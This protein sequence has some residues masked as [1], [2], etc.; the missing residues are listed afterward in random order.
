MGINR[1]QFLTGAAVAASA[2]T[3]GLAGCSGNSSDGSATINFGWWGNPVRNQETDR[4]IK[5]YVKANPKVTIKQQPGEWDSYWD[6]L[7]TEVAGK[8]APDV[9]QMDMAYISQYAKNGTLLDLSKYGVDVSKFAPGTADAGRIDGKLVGVNAGINSLTL[10][11]NPKVFEKAGVD[12]P[13]DTKWTWDDYLNI[14]AE[15]Q[16][17]GPS[18]TT[19]TQ[20]AFPTD[21]MLEIWLRQHGKDLYTADGIAFTADDLT[22]YLNLMVEFMNKKAIPSASAINEEVGKSMDQTA[23]GMGTQGFALYWTNQLAAINDSSGTTMTM[24][25]PPTVAGD[26]RQRN[27]WYKASMLWSGYAGTKDPEAVGKLI[28]WWVNSTTCADIC[29]DERGAP[30]N[31]D[32][33]KAIESK[34]TDAGK[35]S[36]KFLD[37]IK[38]ELGKTPIAPPAGSSQI[39]DIMQR[40]TNDILFGKDQPET[41]APKIVSELQ[42]AIKSAQ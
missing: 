12:L 24:L 9:I 1:R 18:G 29:L 39:G 15:L 11:A 2:T 19:G 42:A 14:S 4:A 32:M 40:H 34:L 30:A 28:N 17:K 5:A 35:A 27:A 22:Q 37:D 10:M 8:N 13:D 26:A 6:K 23:F 31:T 25:R 33:V 36:V 3:L 38:P 21:N 20:C 7:S 16:A 41:A